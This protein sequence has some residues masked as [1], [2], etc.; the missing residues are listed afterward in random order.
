MKLFKYMSDRNWLL[1]VFEFH[2]DSAALDLLACGPVH[3]LLAVVELDRHRNRLTA[4]DNSS[5]HIAP[6]SGNNRLIQI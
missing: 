6:K 2:S 1:L 4:E 5:V 3:L